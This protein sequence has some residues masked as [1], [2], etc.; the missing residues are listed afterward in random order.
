[1]YKPIAKKIACALKD[2]DKATN[3]KWKARHQGKYAKSDS[4]CEKCHT[5]CHATK[6]RKKF[7]ITIVFDTMTLRNVTV[8]TLVVSTRNPLTTS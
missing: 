6:Q 1:M 2:H 7:A 8:F 4:H 5:R 3:A